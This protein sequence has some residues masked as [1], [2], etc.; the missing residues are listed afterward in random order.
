M[1]S[2]PVGVGLLA[3]SL[4]LSGCLS[5]TPVPEIASGAGLGSFAVA[6]QTVGD[7]TLVPTACTSGDRQFFLGGDFKTAGSDLVVRLVVD[8]L[9]APAVRVFSTE[10]EFDKSVVFKRAD[11]SVFHFSLDTTGWRVNDVY[12]YQLTLQ[13]DCSKPGES[14]RGTASTTHCH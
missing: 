6:S 1:R 8:P 7:H 12:D 2:A 3:A 10:A 9:G 4:L 14:L 5:S 11:C 13:L